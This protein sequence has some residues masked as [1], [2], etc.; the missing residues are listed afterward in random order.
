MALFQIA[1]LRAVSWNLS[2]PNSAKEGGD[3]YEGKTHLLRLFGFSI[4][5][6]IWAIETSV[7]ASVLPA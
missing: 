1:I 6:S 2:V 4:L 5:D 3:A 7:A